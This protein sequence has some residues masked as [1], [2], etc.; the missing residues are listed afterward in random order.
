[1]IDEPLPATAVNTFGKASSSL[2]TAFGAVSVAVTAKA[3]FL[4]VATKTA[5]VSWF[6]WPAPNATAG[7]EH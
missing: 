2:E 6:R 4:S 1:M 3:P 5:P 7:D